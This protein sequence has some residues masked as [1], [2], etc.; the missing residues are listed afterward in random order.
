[1]ED[2]GSRKVGSFFIERNHKKSGPSG[3]LGFYK[4]VFDNSNL[5]DT[6]NI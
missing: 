1:M 5:D 2:S 6:F 3:P 4:L